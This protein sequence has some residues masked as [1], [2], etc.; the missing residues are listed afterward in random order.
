MKKKLLKISNGKFYVQDNMTFKEKRDSICNF[1][2]EEITIYTKANLTL[3]FDITLKN[4]EK[5]TQTCYFPISYLN[6]PL[7][8]LYLGF[9]SNDFYITSPKKEF[10]SSM[11]EIINLMRKH[12]KLDTCE[13]NY[14]WELK[15]IDT[16][17]NLSFKKM[18]LFGDFENPGDIVDTKAIKKPR[19]VLF[20]YMTLLDM[21]VSA[22]LV[23]FMLLSLM[24]SLDILGKN[25]KP[26]F[27]IAIVGGTAALR[28]KIALFYTNLYKRDP[29]FNSN[30]YE[31]FHINKKDTVADIRLKAALS[32]DCVLI[33]FEPDKRHL[34]VLLKEIYRINVLESE[35]TAPNLLLYTTEE[36]EQISENTIVVQLN[37]KH[38]DDAIEKYFNINRITA[39]FSVDDEILDTD[40][41]YFKENIYYYIKKLKKK[42]N[43]NL[44]YIQK[45]F[46]EHHERYCNIIPPSVSETAWEANELLMFGFN[47]YSKFFEID[48][49]F[50]IDVANSIYKVTT[51]SFPLKTIPTTSDIENAKNVCR[52]I[53]CYFEK[54]KN[55]S[56]IGKIGAETNPCE[57]S[58]WY[59]EDTIYMTLHRAHEFLKLTNSNLS[60]S[61]S[62]KKALAH[63]GFIKSYTKKDNKPEYTVHIQKALQAKNM[64]KDDTNTYASI[65]T[66]NRYIAFNRD[67]CSQHNLFPNIEKI[68]ADRYIFD[69]ARK[70]ARE[71][72]IKKD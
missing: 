37:D 64:S 38:N 51:D 11:I 60:F 55:K 47:M 68:I 21:D 48:N 57:K 10:E 46:K 20:E 43:K 9:D 50:K 70:K 29:S 8:W 24:T 58:V 18:Y 54:Q 39:E 23:C 52:Q 31:M 6:D 63:A 13:I 5:E 45:K 34:N 28:R 53:D 27:N 3:A 42:L 56:L 22:P 17:D 72:K 40:R 49:A 14:G 61:I 33:A 35:R 30:E 4:N 65:K 36:Y 19:N 66:R 71:I 44:D 41:D 2:I 32:K 67:I 7:S 26:K 16:K 1:H 25:I 12:N 62:I 69:V 59:D 15:D